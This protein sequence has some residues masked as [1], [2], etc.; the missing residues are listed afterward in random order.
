MLKSMGL[1]CRMDANTSNTYLTQRHEQQMGKLVAEWCKGKTAAQVADMERRLNRVREKKTVEEITDEEMNMF[2]ELDKEGETGFLEFEG[3]AT[4]YPTLD[5]Y[6]L[7]IK[8]GDVLVLG[9]YTNLGKSTLSLDWCYTFCQAGQNVLFLAMEDNKGEMD[10]R[11]WGLLKARGI[12]PKDALE[13]PGKFYRFPMA[14]KTVFFR[15]KFSIIPTIEAMVLTRNINIVC[16]DMLNDVVDPINDRDADEFMVALKE[17]CDKLNVILLTTSRL[18]EP[19]GLNAKTQ[20]REKFAPDEDAIYGRG[21]IK[22]LATK[23]ITLAISS[24][25]DP[26]PQVAF[27]GHETKYL[28]LNVCKNRNGRNTKQDGKIITFEFQRGASI[29]MKYIDRGAEDLNV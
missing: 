14:K 23:I 16:L 18:R 12:T 3:L 6:L 2:A 15:D 1:G 8:P 4:G 9:A 5:S 22:Y 10:S 24:L 25:H 26:K 19:K 28:S 21:M 11:A 29:G 7:G 13:W 27:S 17:A 20:E